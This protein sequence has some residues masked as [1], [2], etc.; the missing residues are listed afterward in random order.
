MKCIAVERP[1][2]LAKA[3]TG[4]IIIESETRVK[5]IGTSFKKEIMVGDTIKLSGTSTV[6]ISH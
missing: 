3:A 4:K 6:S 1:Q 5:G 2:D